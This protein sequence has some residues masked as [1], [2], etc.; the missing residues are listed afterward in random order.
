MRR[1]AFLSLLMLLATVEGA[2]SAPPRKPE[3]ECAMRGSR[4]RYRELVHKGCMERATSAWVAWRKKCKAVA[5]DAEQRAAEMV[6]A[7]AADQERKVSDRLIDMAAAKRQSARDRIQAR[8][9]Q[10]KRGIP[11]NCKTQ[12]PALSD[13]A[14]SD[15]VD[16][17]AEEATAD[18]D[19]Q[20]ADVDAIYD[21]ELNAAVKKAEEKKLQIIAGMTKERRQARE[22]V[23]AE[24]GSLSV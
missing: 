8:L 17:L 23:L 4:N 13:D 15:C 2:G 18:A 14:S 12:G 1:D 6:M 22:M 11:E 20:K 16:R 3:E 19:R 9:E 10:H 5:V 7:L 24:R 21:S